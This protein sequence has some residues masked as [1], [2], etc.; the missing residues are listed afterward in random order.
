MCGRFASYKNQEKLK[1]IFDLKNKKEKFFSSYNICPG[2]NISVIFNYEFHNYVLPSTWGYSIVNN[3]IGKKQLVINSRIETINT[4]LL[5][6][7][8]FLKRKCIIPINGYYEWKIENN[9]KKPFYIKLGDS[10]LIF[11]AGIWRKEIINN[12]KIRVFSII[13]KEANILTLDIHHRM[14][15]ILNANNAIH[16]L[17]N[18][19][20]NSLLNEVYKNQVIDLNYHE[21][22]KYVNTPKNNDLKCLQP[23]N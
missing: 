17:E 12:Q 10:E 13:T 14:P 22:S 9:K 5:F 23:I 4:K 3:D 21:V 16:Y 19:K 6:K 7:E 11:L 20:D 15:M 18:Q 2:Q 8:S 1:S